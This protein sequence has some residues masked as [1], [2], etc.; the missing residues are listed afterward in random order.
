MPRLSTI[1]QGSSSEPGLTI[2]ASKSETL[3]PRTRPYYCSERQTIT[4]YTSCS[5]FVSLLFV[6]V[7]EF[8]SSCFTCIR[9]GNKDNFPAAVPKSVKA[10]SSP[11]ICTKASCLR[12]MKSEKQEKP[13]RER[14]S[15]PSES[16]PVLPAAK[17]MV[18]NFNDEKKEASVNQK[19]VWADRY[20]PKSLKDFICNRSE[21]TRLL[22]L[23]E[24]YRGCGHVIFEGPPGVGKKTMI[25]AMLR[26]AFGPDRVQAREECKAFDL[27]GESRGRIEVNVKESSKH[28]EINL[29]DLKGYEKHV[30]AELMKETQTKTSKSNKALSSYSENCRVIVLCEADSLS[31]DVLLYIKW[32]LERYKGDYRVF[33][34]CCDVSKLEPI[35]SLCTLFQLL[36]P[37]KEEIV[38]VLEFIAKQEGIYLPHKL[39]EKVANNS[40]N[41]LRQAIRSFEACCHSSYPFKEDQVILT[42]WE[43]HI[44]EIAKNMVEERSPKQLYII[45][46]KLQILIE[47]DV[48]PDFIFMSL[49]GELKKHLHQNLHPEVDSL[50]DEYNG[51]HEG[52]IER[53]NQMG[54]KVVDPVKNNKRIFFR[55]EEFVA[56]FMSC[57]NNQSR[58]ANAGNTKTPLE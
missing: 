4:V 43:E 20:R 36:P 16:P 2:T 51:S 7:K 38:E 26:D 15:E 35:R 6:K 22:A 55:I 1:P 50:Y 14:V 39:A 28:V 44:A 31:T 49:V 40:K 46:G 3:I 42:G 57:Y 56:R 52:M 53:E 18:G 45:R 54:S 37:S 10:A 41:N 11:S 48:P 30:I 17:T 13:L 58:M 29:S 8:V 12:D 32:L 23:E 19:F 24:K 27:K 21:A 9:T 47:H 5:I 33:F 25:W 34:C